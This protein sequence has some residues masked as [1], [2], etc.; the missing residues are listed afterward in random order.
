MLNF[1][2]LLRSKPK[3]IAVTD[4]KKFLIVGLGNIGPKY[5]NTRHNIG[6]KVLDYLAEEASLCYEAVRLS[7]PAQYDPA[8][9]A[10]SP[11]S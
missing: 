8:P 2:R 9:T 4:M 7:D 5:H 6:F 10:P 1:F 11:V 3:D